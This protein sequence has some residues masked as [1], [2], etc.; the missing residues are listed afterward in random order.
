MSTYNPSPE[1]TAPAP[2]RPASSIRRKILP[3]LTGRNDARVAQV[4]FAER[5]ARVVLD[6]AGHIQPQEHRLAGIHGSDSVAGEEIPLALR[7]DERLFPLGAGFMSGRGVRV[8]EPLLDRHEV[9][10]ANQLRV[11]FLRL[12]AYLRP[13]DRALP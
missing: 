9:L 4:D 5:I 10:A 12:R 3:E 1:R 6:V 13:L 2:A 11:K 8:P 7:E